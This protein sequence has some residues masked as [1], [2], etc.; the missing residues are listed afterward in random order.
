VGTIPRLMIPTFA[1]DS[2]E[3]KRFNHGGSNIVHMVI[4]RELTEDEEI[5][6]SSKNSGQDDSSRR[7]S[8][9]CGCVI[10]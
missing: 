5:K 8:G 7:S 10:L 6:D 4:K 1:H 3:D 9:C 2:C